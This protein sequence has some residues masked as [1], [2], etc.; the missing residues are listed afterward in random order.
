MFYLYKLN[1]EAELVNKSE[2]IYDF[3]LDLKKVLSKNKRQE[4]RTFLND[5][6]Q[7]VVDFGF[8]SVFYVIESDSDKMT[9]KLYKEFD[10]K[11]EEYCFDN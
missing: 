3:L 11:L 6:G 10:H 7:L 8:F 4:F 2:D 9:E 5:R 1:E